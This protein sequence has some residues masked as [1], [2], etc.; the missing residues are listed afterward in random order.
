[1]Q[2]HRSQT[3]KCL[4]NSGAE[5]DVLD[6]HNRRVRYVIRLIKSNYNEINWGYIKI[7]SVDMDELVHKQLI[8]IS[9][10]YAM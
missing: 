9:R 8:R 1:M 7:T 2:T 5:H 10:P 3:N 6:A 4:Q